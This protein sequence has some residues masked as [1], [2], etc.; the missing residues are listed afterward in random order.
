[1]IGLFV[2]LGIVIAVVFV[3]WVGA[4]RYFEKGK[5][6]ATYFDESVQG[7]QVD[8][9]VKY[10]GVDVGRVMKIRVAP[11]FRLVEVI[12]KIKDSGVVDKDTVAELKAAGITG[13][14]FIELDR[15]DQ[16]EGV[17]GPQ[18]TFTPE[19]PVIPSR[20]ST[21]KQIY[22]GLVE[23]YEKVMAVDLAGAAERFKAAASSIDR[24]FGGPAVARTI[25][26]LEETSA[27]LNGTLKKLNRIVEEGKVDAVLVEAHRGL[28]ETRKMVEELRA[29][30]REM[31]LAE[32]SDR[33][34]R[35]SDNLEQRS[36][37]I[38]SGLEALLQ[39]VRRNSEQLNRLLERVNDNPSALIF[40]GGGGEEGE[41]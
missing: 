4:S 29:E 15:R 5:V 13:I 37:R 7:L 14:V 32:R 28:T 9:T 33:L 39:G 22:A 35:L 36:R 25:A 31:K 34:G 10:R 20:P 11:D 8:S 12:L 30:I 27:S 23:I 21:I 6:Y 18:L 24:L 26:S 2:T 1:M 3:I 16:K 38:A 19:Y 41:R 17:A 40:G